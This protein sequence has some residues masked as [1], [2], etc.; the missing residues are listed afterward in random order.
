M[1]EYLF[2]ATVRLGNTFTDTAGDAYDPDTIELKI[3]DAEGTLQSTVT[4]GASDISSDE[5]GVYYYDYLIP[6]DATSQGYWIGVWT[7]T[8]TSTS[9]VDISEEQF[10]AR[11]AAEKLYTSV[12][13]V[14]ASLMSTGVTMAD[15]DV[16]NT[17][18]SS[19]AEVDTITGRNFTS[20]N[21]RTEWFDTY[22]ANQDTDV[23]TIF[24]TYIPIQSIT[25][26]KEFTTSN[27]LAKTFAADD[28]WCDDNGVL[29]LA[30]STFGQQRHRV[31]CKYTYGYTSVPYKISKLCSVIAQIEVLR[32][33]MIMQD[34]EITGFSI[35][36]VSQIQLGETYM[37]AQLAIKELE[38]Q[39]KMLIKEIG[40]LRNDV[41]FV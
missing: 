40:S 2:G 33:Y 26:V 10:Y 13:E 17:I 30:R 19:M 28:Y 38:D 11:P 14:K 4:H 5:P 20:G 34:S 7:I 39:K 8:I 29:E 41:F 3:Y 1:T 27:V 18:R 36:D 15:D 24:L 23:T 6:A 22:Q 35:P 32:H 25:S 21:T 31:E 37:T 9:Q 12:S 16:R